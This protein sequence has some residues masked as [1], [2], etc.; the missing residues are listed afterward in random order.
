M[1]AVTRRILLQLALISFFLLGSLV[2]NAR[3]LTSE[4]LLSWIAASLATALMSTATIDVAWL[5]WRRRN[6]GQP[7]PGLAAIGVSAL[8]G[9]VFACTQIA[10]AQF[11]GLAVERDPLTS[12]VG[13]IVTIT[14]IGT[15]VASVISGH[16]R[17][18]ERRL[19]LLEEGIAVSLV[20]EDVTEI[21]HR[22]QVA[23]GTE[24][25][26]ALAPARRGI[27]ERLADQQHAL[28]EDEWAATARELRAAAQDTV[29]PLSRELWSSTA[30]RLAPI[31]VSSVLRN[32]ITR[33]PF[34]PVPLT[35]IL[36]VTSLASSITLYGWGVGVAVVSL[37]IALIFLVLG[38]ANTAMYRWPT[39]HAAF[40][41][42][43]ALVLELLTLINFPLRDWQQTRPYTWGE[44]IA[45]MIFGFIFIL[46]TSGAGSLR[47]HRDDVARTFQ[48]EIDRELIA[49]I[50][51]SRQVA[52]LAR[53]TAR[54]LH[55]T[56]QTRLIACAVAME[57]ALDIKDVYAFQEALREAHDVLA[58][59]VR[60]EAADATTLGAEVERKVSLWS[61]LCT[62]TVEIDP[63]LAERTGQSAR[64][65]G[66]VVEEG[67]SNAIRHG[68]AS[69]IQ[70]SVQ[71]NADQI[72]VVIEDD[73][74]G[75]Q[76]G[77]PGL[78]SA[79]L[80]SIATSWQ[81]AP[82]GSGCRLHVSI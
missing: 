7:L 2:G 82:H 71:A 51:L 39:H 79:L 64:D 68:G 20:R 50:A 6:A 1:N 12:A 44:A 65:I 60:Y 52:Q 8:V 66:R 27:E 59:P 54:I 22:M 30:G 62:I 38:V 18:E 56:V 47:T 57:R 10:L 9:G 5:T 40:F 43:G 28:N 81:L 63:T 45:A 73:G 33:Q 29:R 21:V 78:G 32:I 37:G 17:E 41:I 36:I 53:E 55:G 61:G 75:P 35:L 4:N 76:M 77:T 15:A 72:T 48:T 67:L 3:V 13:S 11:L 49:S 70:V 74:S 80:D 14:I 16:R 25:D 34:R 23:L 69:S 24:I 42:G 58:E 19:R 46:L 26:D 31:R